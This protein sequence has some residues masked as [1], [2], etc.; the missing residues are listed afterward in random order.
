MANTTCELLWLLALL[1]DFGFN[2]TTP[3]LMY[4]DNK[5]SIHI[6]ENPVLHERTKHVDIDW[7]ITREHVQKGQLKL[8][9]VN[10]KSNLADILTNLSIPI[11][12]VIVQDECYKF[13]PSILRGRIKIINIILFFID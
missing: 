7:H 12:G 13:L 10:T 5:A 3:A 11:K 8:L 9:H 2:H 4:C 1:K 6:S